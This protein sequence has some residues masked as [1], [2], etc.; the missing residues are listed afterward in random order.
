MR[1]CLVSLNICPKTPTCSTRIQRAGKYRRRNDSGMDTVSAYLSVDFSFHQAGNGSRSDTAW[2]CWYVIV[3]HW[4][5]SHSPN[6][7]FLTI[8]NTII[9]KWLQ[10]A[11][12]IF[13]LMSP[14]ITMQCSPS[15]ISLGCFE[16]IRRIKWHWFDHW[17]VILTKSILLYVVRYMTD[18][19][20]KMCSS[21]KKMPM[22]SSRGPLNCG[23]VP[24]LR[25]G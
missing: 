23:S 14:N 20:C 22:F 13:L 1:Y 18:Y 11:D 6:V 2:V 3:R 24:T 21:E 7:P 10:I 15:Q 16:S 12:T 17:T 25:W 4:F 9:E 5:F 19:A 8:Y